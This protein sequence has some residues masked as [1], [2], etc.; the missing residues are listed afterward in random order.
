VDIVADT[1]PL[2]QYKLVVAPALNVLT[3]QAAKNL[4]AYVRAGGHL[5]LGQRSAM[6]DEDNSLFP[7]RQPGPLAAL[8]GARVEQF[9]ALIKTVPVN[10]VWGDA[11]DTVWAEQLGVTDPATQVLMRYGVSNG[12]LELLHIL[13][14][15]STRLP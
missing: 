7:E 14:R 6:K 12:W 8:L 13:V 9:Y 1:A 10:G 15:H 11:Q 5:V 4:E 2:T 3:P